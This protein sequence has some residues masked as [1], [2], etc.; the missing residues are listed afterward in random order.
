MSVIYAHK[1]LFKAGF[2]IRVGRPGARFLGDGLRDR[3]D[4]SGVGQQ[5]FGLE[6]EIKSGQAL[7]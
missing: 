1:N 2:A 7:G 3:A 5:I 6:M 4:L